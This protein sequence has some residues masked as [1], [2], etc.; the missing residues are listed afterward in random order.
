MVALRKASRPEFLTK[1][2]NIAV[3]PFDRIAS[4]EPPRFFNAASASVASGYGSRSRFLEQRFG[5]VFAG[6]DAGRA[7]CKFE[8]HPREVR[9]VA[10]L[11]KRRLQ[12]GIFK[13]LEPPDLCDQIALSGTKLFGF[14]VDRVHVVERAVGVEDQAF[15]RHSRLSLFASTA[16]CLTSQCAFTIDSI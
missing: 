16:R 14:G 8:R 9:E 13:L 12:P 5:D 6:L 7:Q 10:I 11:L 15:D 1:A 2:D 3:L 4:C